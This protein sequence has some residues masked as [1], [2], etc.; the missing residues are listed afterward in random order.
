[1]HWRTL[2]LDV[3][4]GI[5]Q[6]VTFMGQS[7]FLLAHWL[8]LMIFYLHLTFRLSCITSVSS[9]PECEDIYPSSTSKTS[10]AFCVHRFLATIVRQFKELYYKTLFSTFTI[11][12][13]VQRLVFAAFER[14][15]SVSSH[16]LC[17]G[18]RSLCSNTFKLRRLILLGV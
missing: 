15:D 9:S 11:C 8:H 7:R 3:A 5:F 14:C 10:L 18:F 6:F 17:G 4:I 16:I 1:M 13:I 12:E 2:R